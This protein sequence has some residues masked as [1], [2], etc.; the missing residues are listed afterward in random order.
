M[1]KRGD[2]GIWRISD[3]GEAFLLRRFAKEADAENAWARL[4]E[5]VGEHDRRYTL[6]T[7]Y[8]YPPIT[9]PT[10]RE[11]P[12]LFLG[13]LNSLGLLHLVLEVASN[14]TDQFL[15][16]FGT[17]VWIR[18]TDDGFEVE[19]DGAG[20]HRDKAKHVLTH[21]HGMAT[22]D[23]HAPHIHLSWSGV[24]VCPVNAVCSEFIVESYDKRGGWLQRY[25]KGVLVDES[26]VKHRAGTLVK[27]T[28]DRTILMGAFPRDL[29]RRKCFE[30]VHIIPGLRM[31]LDQ[32]TFYAPTGLL[33]LAEFDAAANLERPIAGHRRFGLNH[34]GEEIQFSIA[35]LGETKNETRL[36]SWVNGC[37][38][39]EH[40]THVDGALEA[41]GEFGWYPASLYLSVVMKEPE[42]AGP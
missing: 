30:A 19:D 37:R 22:A 29:L 13:D 12:H 15:M 11:R 32:E 38:T 25:A 27:A 14:S 8:S 41:L 26:G 33:S 17:Q 39:E 36:L 9:V 4:C 31:S 16:G 23:N 40:G 10:V 28:F 5:R 24:G 35:C 34:D 1:M 42:Y 20:F 2:I 21:Y 7:Q 3:N 6:K 18:L